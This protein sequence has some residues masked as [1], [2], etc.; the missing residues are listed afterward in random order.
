M[1]N[2]RLKKFIEQIKQKN[3]ETNQADVQGTNGE[4]VFGRVREKETLNNKQ[5]SKTKYIYEDKS[6]RSANARCY[7]PR[8]DEQYQIGRRWYNQRESTHDRLYLCRYGC[9][10]YMETAYGKHCGIRAMK[11]V[12]CQPPFI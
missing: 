12:V 1:Y 7:P 8:S 3:I 11:A 9:K 10:S 4:S 5:N 2:E 6:R